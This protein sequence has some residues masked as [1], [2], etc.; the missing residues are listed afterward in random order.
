M[1]KIFCFAISL[2]ALS[3]CHNY[4]DKAYDKQQSKAYY[5]DWDR[6]I[7]IDVDMQNMYAN[8]PRKIERPI[9]MYMAMALALKY[10]YTGKMI[11]YEE[12]LIK[13]GNSN[14][15]QLQEILNNAGYINTNNSSQIS[16]DLKVAWNILDMSTVY[17][18]TS[19]PSFKANIAI[20][21]SRKVT[22]NILQEARLLYWKALT[23]QRL[24]PVID[25]MSEYMTLEVDEMNATAKEL[26]AKGEAPSRDDLIKKRKYM[27]SVKNLATLKRDLETAQSRLASLMGFHPSTEFKLVGAQYGNFELPDI[28]AN[29][30]QLEWLAL[31]NRPELRVHDIISTAADKE[32]VIQKFRDENQSKYTNA[33]Q[34][35]KQWS[36]QGCEV[37][38]SAIQEAQKADAAMLETLRRQRMTSLILNQVYVSWAQYLSATEDYQ[39]NMEIANTSE[40]IA[41]DF[42]FTEGEQNE[43]SQLEAARAIED[44]VKAFLS[45]VDV[46]EA[47][48]NLYATI[49]LDSVPY[50]MLGEKPSNIA[51]HLNGNMTKW[52]DGE[53]IPDN[54]PYLL[55]IPAKRP[56]VN[57][58]SKIKLPDVNVET[59]EPIYITIKDDAFEPLGWKGP[60]KTKAGLIDDSKLP[61]W[62]KYN[63]KKQVFTGKAMPNDGGTYHIK[64]YA[65]ED[66]TGNVAY[67][68]FKLNVRE[69]Y[70]PS[71]KVRGLTQGRGALVLKRCRGKKCK[72]AYVHQSEIGKEVEKAPIIKK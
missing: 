15:A 52:G 26:A 36:K 42:T 22:H 50:Y 43:R 60:I 70:V 72:D 17:Y 37:G 20:E 65:V 13:A 62:L 33:S 47:L 49:G 71:M 25:Q 7:R 2:L 11:A 3:A 6:A 58:T 28:K 10:N 54:R 55:D 68:T 59:G 53:L 56:P 57:V 1:K 35:Y 19:D 5:S 9:D 31:S 66:N 48:G 39:I 27:E 14:Y 12:N 16:P 41:E 69:V 45:Y 30:S 44:E 18:Q 64:I 21:Q 61:K 67:A 32:M 46:Q 29:L 63:T 24:L 4:E 34:H 23:A 8:T 38:M 51:I 40:N